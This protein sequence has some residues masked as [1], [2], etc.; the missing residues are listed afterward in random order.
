MFIFGHVLV[1]VSVYLVYNVKA[2]LIN[3]YIATLVFR[4][5]ILD[6]NL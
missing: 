5:R 2:E 3:V 6:S 1:G 4:I